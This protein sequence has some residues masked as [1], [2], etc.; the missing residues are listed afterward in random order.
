MRY[1]DEAKQDEIIRATVKL[2]NQVGFAASSVSKIAKEADVS[3]A[4]IYI[5][6]KNKEDLLVSTYVDIKQKLSEA[7]LKDFDDSQPIRDIL[8]ACWFKAFNFISNNPGDYQYTEQFANSP[9]SSLVNKSE[10]DKHFEPIVKVIQNG[11]QQKIIKDDSLDI[12]LIFIFYPITILTNPR[13]C[14]DFDCNEKSIEMA[15]N[16]AWDAIKL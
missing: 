9:Y 12:L 10:V 16:M 4:T 7:I 2:V 11:I 15:F 5:Y 13:L 14:A 1:K 8:K 3:P 6:Y